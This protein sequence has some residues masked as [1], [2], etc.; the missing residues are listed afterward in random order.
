MQVL[1]GCSWACL[2][3]GSLLNLMRRNVEKATCTGMLGSVINLAA[4]SGA[5]VGGTISELFGF[6][7]AMYTAAALAATGFLLFRARK[8]SSPIKITSQYLR[9]RKGGHLK[10]V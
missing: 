8:D 10:K 7:S 9:P 3:V 5:L 1:L 6:K 4:L 2:Y